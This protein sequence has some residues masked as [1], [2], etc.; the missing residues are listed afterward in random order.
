MDLTAYSI[1]TENNILFYKT[2]GQPGIQ[3]K[4]S[5]K[6]SGSFVCEIF[7]NVYNFL[8]VLFINFLTA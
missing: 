7:L 3:L 5:Y 6:Q 8:R 4:K 1:I 2:G